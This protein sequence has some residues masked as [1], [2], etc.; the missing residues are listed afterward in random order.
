MSRTV[1]GTLLGFSAALILS[2]CGGDGGVTPPP[3]P[4]PTPPPANP[5]NVRVVTAGDAAVTVAW[6]QVSG[7]TSYNLYSASQAGVTKANFASKPDGARRTNVTSPAAV[8]GLVNGRTYFFLVT[9]VGTGGESRESAEVNATPQAAFAPGTSTQLSG[10]NYTYSSLNIAAGVTVTV[11]GAVVITVT[12]NATIAGTLT[13]DCTA[14]DIRVAG[15]LTIDG[16]VRNTCTVL[17]VSRPGIKLLADGELILGTTASN[18]DAIVSDGSVRITD[19]ATENAD[20]TPIGVF[21]NVRSSPRSSLRTPT[22]PQQVSPQA[23]MA[24]PVRAQRGDDVRVTRDGPITVGGAINAGNGADAPVKN[25]PGNCDNSLALGGNGGTI[26]FAARNSTLTFQ[27]G[28]TLQAGNGGKGGNCTAPSGCPATALA[29]RGGDGGSI[30]VGATTIVFEAG[31]T[32]NRGNG[33]LG[34]DATATADDG[35]AACANGCDATA[36]G[37]KGGNAGGI[38]YIITVP[39]TI[40]GNPTESGANGG[41][42]GSATATGGDGRDCNVCPGGKGGD[43]GAATATGGQGGDG[44]TRN[45]FPRAADSHRKGNGGPS[46]AVGGNGGEGAECC[47]FLEGGDGGK[48]GNATSTGGQIGAV[49]VGGNGNRGTDTGNGGNGGNGGDGLG[50]GDGGLKGTGTGDP[51]DIP[52]GAD[53][54]DG[55][56]CVVDIWFIYFS[57]INDGE[58]TPGSTRTLATYA[59]MSP[60]NPTGTVVAR[61][62]T[63]SEVGGEVQHIKSGNQM[64]VPRGG[65]EVPLQTLLPG[66]PVGKVRTRFLNFCLVAQCVQLIGYYQGVE[67]ARVGSANTNN[68]GE[69]QTIELPPPS[70]FPYYDKFVL[71]GGPF[72]FDHWWILIIDP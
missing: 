5:T 58:I 48:G 59:S 28:T 37:G 57:S 21:P 34:G 43:G 35:P 10:G 32:L 29:G 56:D 4:P 2:S 47:K 46:D 18:Q 55:A 62:M 25:Q 69:D 51:T 70:G 17:P 30:L 38:G 65:I 20:F 60:V 24:R 68:S 44:A 64:L 23:R 8:T 26:A 50:P 22:E 33:G 61:F 1:C 42:G 66:F 15:S 36:T 63:S 14:I 49:G 41:T 11:T 7:A 40:N 12:G 45:I 31:V 27:A 52:D 13:G 39:G 9:A 67:R 6:D 19:T 53:G 54:A 72:H 71:I 3:P 16:L